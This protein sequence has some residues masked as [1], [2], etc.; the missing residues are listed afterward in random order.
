MSGSRIPYG[1]IASI[2]HGVSSSDSRQALFWGLVGSLLT[3]VSVV[4]TVTATNLGPAGGGSI[5]LTRETFSD[6]DVMEG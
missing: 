4:Y 2:G 3:G 5:R 6:D 1:S